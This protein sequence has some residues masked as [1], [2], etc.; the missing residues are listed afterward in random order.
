M[1]HTDP[2]VGVSYGEE[3]GSLEGLREN[4]MVG[5]CRGKSFN[6]GVVDVEVGLHMSCRL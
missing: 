2:C 6:V 3:R 1:V 5:G 4:L